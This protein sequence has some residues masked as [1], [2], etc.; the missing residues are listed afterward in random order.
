MT[1]Y[2]MEGCGEN[3]DVRDIIVTRTDRN[4]V[5]VYATVKRSNPKTPSL[6]EEINTGNTLD[7]LR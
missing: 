2:E 6:L 3:C 4:D 1:P 7:A 5:L